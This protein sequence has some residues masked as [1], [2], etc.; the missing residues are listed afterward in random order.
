LNKT[1]DQN[2]MISLE[3]KKKVNIKKEKKSF[4]FMVVRKKG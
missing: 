1:D 3:E 2:E 4:L